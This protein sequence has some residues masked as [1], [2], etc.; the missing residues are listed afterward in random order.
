MQHLIVGDI[1]GCYDEFRELL[2]KA[3]LC[4]GDAVIAL[5]DIVD[6]GP[7]TAR[8]LEFFRT[9]PDAA[10]LMGNH[11]RKH[12]RS[13]RHEI[14]PATSQVIARLQIGETA[15]PEA[16]ACM[17][18]FPVYVELPDALLIHG[19]FEPGVPIASQREDVLCGVTSGEKY[20]CRTCHQPWY[21]MYDQ[22]QPLVVGH[23]DYGNNGKPMIVR[24][25]NSNVY[26]ID[27]GCCYGR[28]LTGLLLPA[29]RLISV[30]SRRDYWAEFRRKYADVGIPRP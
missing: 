2:E 13:F 26:C 28:K 16:I 4:S 17:S 15:Y 24:A 27:T 20:I 29:F 11:E 5:G 1:H 9:A 22:H 6:R 23:H 14:M 18:A 30:A 19:F 7:D 3:G 25:R 10:S 12:I 21:K 8:V